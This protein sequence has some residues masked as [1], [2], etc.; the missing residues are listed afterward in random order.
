MT[1]PRFR[2][3]TVKVR[4]PAPPVPLRVIVCCGLPGELS[5]SV[6]APLLSPAADGKRHR[7]LASPFVSIRAE[8]RRERTWDTGHGDNRMISS[9]S[10]RRR[11]RKGDYPDS[12]LSSDYPDSFLSRK[13]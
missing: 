1:P 8:S 3:A 4:A 6:T 2:L 10:S 9:R 12:F 5:L 11:T 7:S 13:I